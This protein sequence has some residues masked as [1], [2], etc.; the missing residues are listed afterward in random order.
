MGRRFSDAHKGIA[1][2]GVYGEDSG[3]IVRVNRALADL[4]ATTRE[5]LVGTSIC[6]RIHSA[7]RDRAVDR[8]LRLIG[9]AG[10]CEGEGR[11]LAEDGRVRWVRV[12][13]ALLPPGDVARPVAML[14][15]AEIA[16]RDE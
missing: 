4:L 14:H 12:F 8:F 6:D 13:A 10:S 3:R 5:E 1:L 2:I 9:G 11:L 16:E 7:D 15:F